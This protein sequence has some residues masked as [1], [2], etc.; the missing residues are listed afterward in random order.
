MPITRPDPI[1]ERIG[2]KVEWRTYATREQAKSEATIAQREA[3]EQEALGY[4]FG[5]Q[6]P[7]SITENED[8]TFT[9]VFP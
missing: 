2:C 9:V 1:H 4:D 6:V 7:G 3:S 8:G 5:Y